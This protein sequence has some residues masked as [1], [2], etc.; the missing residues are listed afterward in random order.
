MANGASDALKV[1]RDVWKLDTWDPILVWYAK[2]VAEMQSRPINDPTSWRYQAAIHEYIRDSDPYATVADK[3]PSD[4][5]RFWNQCQ[6]STWFFLPWHR[7]YLL[8]FEQIV[9]AAVE[10][11]GGPKDWALPYW[12]YSEYRSI[13]KVLQLPPAF[14]AINTPDG[15]PNPLRVEQ[16]DSGLND[17][18]PIHF[19]SPEQ[20]V[21]LSCLGDALFVGLAEGG[22]P[23]FGGPSTRSPRHGGGPGGGLET[24]PHGDMHIAVGGPAGFMSSFATAALDPIFWLHHANID[25][26]WDVWTG[27]AGHANPTDKNWL[28]QRFEFHDKD[29][30]AVALTPGQV[31]TT[32]VAPLAYRYEDVTDPQA[33]PDR[34]LAFA[35]RSPVMPSASVPEMVGATDHAVALT[36]SAATTASMNIVTATGPAR[37]AM[38]AG[39]GTTRQSAYLNIENITSNGVP[40][41]YAVYLD[42]PAGADPQQHQDLFAGTLPMFGVAEASRPDQEHPG[43]GLQYVLEVSAIIERLKAQG[44]WDPSRLAITFVARRQQ[45]GYADVQI[46]RVSLYYQ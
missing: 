43:S 42:L 2:A 27:R 17:G 32:T 18:V 19:Q 21:D 26:L 38:A 3:L 45:G 15:K 23:G 33:Q 6:H 37:M 11:L 31:L 39:P 1:R 35:V 9:A 44:L 4:R 30:E 22:H 13:D 25:R 14:Y 8:Y 20:D 10:K 5:Q 36:A 41:S 29:A 24:T 46:G 12:N 16:R 7:M 34:K 40:G 28:T